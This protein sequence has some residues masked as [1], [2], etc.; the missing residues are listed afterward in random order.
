MIG[1]VIEYTSMA[2]RE[3]IESYLWIRERAPRA[4]EKWREELIGKVESLA[5]NPLRHPV[6]PESG[7]FMQ[8]IRLMLFRK[9][10]SQF[11]IYYTIEGVRVVILT[12]RRSARK[13]LEEDDLLG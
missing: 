10:R 11:R 13:P 5:A 3:V 2:E 4:A 7:K 6:A 9:R 8:E 12:I 1:Y